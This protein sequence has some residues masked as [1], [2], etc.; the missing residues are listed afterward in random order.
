MS[1]HKARL[2]VP[3]SASDHAM[4]ANDAPL[5]L[6]E[7][8]DYQCPYCGQAYSIVKQLQDVFGAALRLVFRNMPLANVHPDAE[9]A[10]EAAE[11]VGLQGKFWPIHD[12][13]F[14]NQCDLSEVAVLRYAE[15]VGADVHEVQ[16]ALSQGVTLE[17]VR[18]DVEGGIRSGVNGTPTFFVNGER[19]DSSWALDPLHEYLKE[20]LES[21]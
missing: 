13:L 17:R 18:A 5:T 7:Y 19:Y 16:D 6:V 2:V 1:E 21:L 11:A 3:V 8:G 10:A 15:D 14:E 4:G 20:V 9:F 12:T